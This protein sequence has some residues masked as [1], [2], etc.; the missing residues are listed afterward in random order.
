MFINFWKRS[1]AFI[2]IPHHLN[3][4]IMGQINESYAIL[5]KAPKSLYSV[6]KYNETYKKYKN[7]TCGKIEKTRAWLQELQEKRN[8]V[9]KKIN[10]PM[11]TNDVRIGQERKYLKLNTQI[12][13]LRDRCM[14]LMLSQIAE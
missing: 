1:F 6:E 2:I 9:S 10:N 12:N 3:I 14:D 4:E 11:V 7:T 5:N 8:E 13:R